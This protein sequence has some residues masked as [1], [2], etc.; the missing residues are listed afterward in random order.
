MIIKEK[1]K[2]NYKNN[3]NVWYI[4][5]FNILNKIIYKKLFIKF[6]YFNHEHY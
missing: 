3:I 1:L 4:N 2:K 5:Y 6:K